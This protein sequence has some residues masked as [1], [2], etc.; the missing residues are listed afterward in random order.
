M[1]VHVPNI[2]LR[3]QRA[4]QIGGSELPHAPPP[5][6]VSQNR[7]LAAFRSSHRRS[8][9][10]SS[11]LWNGATERASPSGD[12]RPPARVREDGQGKTARRAAPVCPPHRVFFV[13]VGVGGGRRRGG[14]HVG[15][16]ASER[17]ASRTVSLFLAAATEPRTSLKSTAQH[18]L[19]APPH[20][21][22]RHN[23]QFCMFLSET[24]VT[25]TPSVYFLILLYQRLREARLGT[26][27]SRQPRNSAVFMQLF[28]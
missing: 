19:A 24:C 8:P 22:D 21:L 26:C 18:T 25:F 27:G 4:P 1:L 16:R 6:A 17:P 5:P 10:A 13:A 28:M 7:S 2:P 3:R 12:L 15:D 23:H 11:V 20:C 9:L 14:E